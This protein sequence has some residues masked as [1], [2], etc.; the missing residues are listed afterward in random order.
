MY[1]VY[2]L[3][4]DSEKSDLK[5]LM[6]GYESI[7]RA[8]P[9]LPVGILH[10]NMKPADKEF[11]MNRFVKDETKI[12][13]ATTVIEV[14]VNVPNASVMVI[15]NAERF[16]LS[17]L[18]QLRGRVGRG[19]DQ[20]YCILMSKYEL[21]KDSRVR[22]DTMVRTNDGFE[23]ADVDLRLR[24]P[25]DLAGTQQSGITDLKIADIGKDSDILVQ[26]RA[27]AQAILEKD[28]HLIE[29][30]NKPIADQLSRLRKNEMNWSRIS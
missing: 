28:P 21:S 22:L 24:G 9:E 18:H 29:M 15:E 16:G 27:S 5:S 13:V 7:C 20:S 26:A 10:G 3:I 12:M 8:F 25:G 23:I 4:E 14:G 6:D 11:E 2:P 30:E 19:S 17:Q 1:I